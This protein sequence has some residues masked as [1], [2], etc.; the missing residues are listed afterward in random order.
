MIDF[1]VKTSIRNSIYKMFLKF[2]GNKTC[3]D[4]ELP[5]FECK[6]TE[7]EKSEWLKSQNMNIL[8]ANYCT[9][10]IYYMYDE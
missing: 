9:W 2:F 4:Y 7:W 10:P 6:G 3:L 8:K 1:D 5:K